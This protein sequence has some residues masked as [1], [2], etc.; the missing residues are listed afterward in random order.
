MMSIILK[1][2]ENSH[3]LGP[4]PSQTGEVDDVPTYV[5]DDVFGEVTENGPNYRNVGWLGTVALMMK[6]QIGLGVLSIPSAFDTLGLAPGIICLCAVAVI[7]TWSDYMI[8][9]F[10]LRHRSVYSVDDVDWVFVSG[11]GMLGISIGLNAVSTHG[12]CTAIFVAV[13]AIVGFM[14]SSIRTLGRITWLAWIGLVCILTAILIVTIAVGIQDRPAAAPQDGVWVSDYKIINNPSFSQAITAVSSI[15][16]AYSGTS[17]FFSIVSEMR[18]PQ[19]YTQAL[20]ICQAGVTA[21]YITIGCVVYYYCGSYVASPALGSAGVMVKKVSYGF[22]LPGLIVTTTIVTHLP[23]KYIFLRILRG[24]K[25]VTANTMI[26]WG[27]WLSCTFG[28]TLIAYVIASAI[29]VFD[30]LVSLIGALLGTLM[31]FQPMGCMWLYDNWSQGKQ[32]RTAQWTLMVCWS[33]FVVLCGSFLTVA[34][35][36]GS[37][38]SVVN[39]YSESGGSAAW[40]CAD[41]SNST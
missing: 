40:S 24:S 28:V 27:T 17:G 30:K 1:S 8:G 15:V 9:A 23:A 3:D 33:V 20:L 19:Y 4:V 12:A 31:S 29:P 18:D 5:N 34:G 38:V 41:N 7:T 36:Y 35:T 26:H 11:S 14:L 22:A 39:S 13:A 37:I 16:F 2:K 6:T 32:E 10:K 21:V 25:H